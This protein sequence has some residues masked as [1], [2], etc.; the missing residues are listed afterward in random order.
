M[1]R[2]LTERCSLHILDDLQYLGMLLEVEGQSFHWKTGLDHWRWE[3][4]RQKCRGPLLQQC[5]LV[6]MRDA[7][8]M[9][10]AG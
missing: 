3:A 1:I 7:K 9:L 4:A 5:Y 2:I 6:V 8:T 10:N